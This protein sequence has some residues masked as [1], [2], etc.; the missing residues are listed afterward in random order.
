M[1]KLPFDEE[2]HRLGTLLNLVRT[3]C[4]AV[5]VCD[6]IG[7]RHELARRLRLLLKPRADEFA[8][9]TRA[10]KFALKP[11]A[12]EFAL[13]SADLD[14][15]AL[16]RESGVQPGDV[17]FFHDV[18]SASAS[19][20]GRL[21]HG[22][23]AVWDLGASIV[24]WTS[25]RGQRR[26]LESAP[27]FYSR[28]VL[29]LELGGPAAEPVTMLSAVAIPLAA[30]RSGATTGGD[31]DASFRNVL[32][33]ASEFRLEV[34]D[35]V[36]PKSFLALSEDPVSALR[37]AFE[38]EARAR[39][40]ERPLQWAIGIHTGSAVRSGRKLLGAEVSRADAIAALAR[41]G[42]T[43]VST[44][45][46]DPIG[47][48]LS[49][50]EFF[51][52]G[53]VGLMGRLYEAIRPGE[54]P[55]G[56][57]R[58]H[59]RLPSQVPAG[60]TFVGRGDELGR[61]A[62]DLAAGASV[63]LLGPRGIGKTAL[64]LEAAR[65]ALLADR[66]TGG[67]AWVSLARDRSAEAIFATLAEQLLPAPSE[68]RVFGSDLASLFEDGATGPMPLEEAGR[69][70]QSSGWPGT[71]SLEHRIQEWLRTSPC[72]LVLDSVDSVSDDIHAMGCIGS[73][74]ETSTA[75]LTA[76]QS[77]PSG[78]LVSSLSR[79]ELLTPMTVQEAESLL[80]VVTRGI[81]S[82]AS[83]SART[84]VLMAAG[85]VPLMLLLLAPLLHS[86]AGEELESRLKA[87]AEG[88]QDELMA[89]SMDALGDS[90]REALA[91]ATVFP[92]DCTVEA[93]QS[94]TACEPREIEELVARRFLALDVDDSEATSRASSWTRSGMKAPIDPR[95]RCRL[96]H[97]DVR[98]AAIESLQASPAWSSESRMRLLRC[99]RFL[100][101]QAGRG[102]DADRIAREWRN[103]VAA[104]DMA[105]ELED[106]P[107][108][109]SLAG[110]LGDFLLRR[111][112]LEE[113]IKLQ[114]LARRAAQ[115]LTLP[116]AE[117]EALL[118]LA[119]LLL[120]RGGDI[121]SGAR[122]SLQQALFLFR[123]SGDVS[124]Q[125]RAL[126]ALG[127]LCCTH[128]EWEDAER[129]YEE[130]RDAFRRIDDRP[131]LQ[132]VLCRLGDVLGFRERVR[133]AEAA[134]LASTQIR[135][136]GPALGLAFV[137]LGRLY[138]RKGRSPDA[139]VALRQ[140][141][142]VFSALGDRDGM[143]NVLSEVALWLAAMEDAPG[144][145]TQPAS[146]GA[147]L[148]SL[149]RLKRGLLGVMRQVA[150]TRTAAAPVRAEVGR[151][152]AVLG[153]PRREVLDPLATEWVEIPA[154]PFWLGSRRDED[155]MAVASEE[156]AGEFD[157]VCPYRISRYP[158]TNAQFGAFVNTGGY[159][160]VRWW[161]EAGTA[162]FWSS[163]GFNGRL[164]DAWRTGPQVYSEPSGLS[165]HPVVGVTWYEALA[166]CRWLTERLRE[167]RLLKEGEVVRLPSEPEWEKAARGDRDH[168]R[169]PWGDEPDRDLANYHDSHLGTT[170][171][172][173]FRR[174]ASPYGV[175]DLSGNAW[176]WTRSL[177]DGHTY[178]SPRPSEAERED[179]AAGPDSLRVLRGGAFLNIAWNV[180]CAS[181]GWSNPGYRGGYLGF[182]V[183]VSPSSPP[184]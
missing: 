136:P 14:P 121:A 26:L 40:E 38:L 123:Q 60:E 72:L 160:D 170:A 148:D 55:R 182:R 39:R 139:I 15:V 168:R 51:D 27:N 154:G 175:E 145:A 52:L 176:E 19:A 67:M 87:V 22:R 61:L 146:P 79:I 133:E 43:L 64:A 78:A 16:M 112:R 28:R 147:P 4:L 156:P 114:S 36:A 171:V 128:S 91:R 30:K 152:L 47:D 125:G 153:D 11:R 70:S 54:L 150:P 158:V 164:D 17:V 31:L 173:C 20:L 181:R 108:V 163:R 83:Q 105:A 155:D 63:M 1:G 161:G 126:L 180:R 32:R 113:G 96:M 151:I 135:E 5:V 74:V 42:Q 9:K 115:T 166:Y 62:D 44:S 159:T 94:V 178:L 130:A 12:Y 24:L 35:S 131:R 124:G 117:G 119:R 76:S 118:G 56:L 49:D 85:G 138:R 82:P 41:G 134:Y 179:L 177:W 66:F 116:A 86:V 23:E 2:L 33:L 106:W 100:F 129:S 140:G 65:G 90:A 132:L 81:V 174:G 77:L 53:A 93:F 165:N 149:E 8:L 104:A 144:S 73:L 111:G 45:T 95:R 169:F 21:E 34:V 68:A 109:L 98:T 172:G 101:E 6:D 48:T 184:A 157:V 167:R 7:M 46:R 58:S 89:L 37:F 59:R 120:A 3:G 29:L 25:A 142:K 137:H 183:I 75:I 127:D 13:K 122:T 50:V 57:S 141:L 88:Q 102:G 97:E 162:G 84:A 18:E 80:R 110:A 107:A 103:G 71:D 69:S 10:D 99:Y 92:E 143:E